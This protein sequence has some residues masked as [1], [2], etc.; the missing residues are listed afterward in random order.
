MAH[1]RMA[2]GRALL[3]G[4]PEGDEPLDAGGVFPQHAQ[5]PVA[6]ARDGHRQF[7]D[8]AQDRFEIELGGE[9]EAGLDEHVEA[10]VVA[11]CPGATLGHRPSLARRRLGPV[12][13]GRW[14]PRGA[15]RPS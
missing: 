8:A 7:D 11:V 13:A 6:G 12:E 9:R 5:R 2:D 10:L 3:I 14:T 15:L 4:D 1:R